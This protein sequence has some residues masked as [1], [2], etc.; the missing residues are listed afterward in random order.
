M[1]VTVNHRSM[2]WNAAALLG[3]LLLAAGCSKKDVTGA[4][5]PPPAVVEQEQGVRLFK[6]DHPDQFPLAVA[7]EYKA[8]ATLNVTGTVN[9]DIN[10]EVPVITLASG[11]VVDTYVQLGDT[12]KKG[13]LLMRVQSTDVSGAFDTY[14]KAV[15]DEH[16]A[17]KSLERAQLLY[18]HGA[19]AQSALQQ[20]QTTEQDAQA[21]VQAADEQL[22]VL[23][24]DKNH[25]GG[26]VN[27][28]APRS[29]VIVQ[30]NVTN[31]AATGV[32]L[33]GSPNAFT[34]ADLSSVWILCDVYE[35]DLPNV[36][37]GQTADI[38]INA[39]PEKV[40]TGRISN[41]S[42]VLDP[43]TRTAK[44]RI[45]VTNPGMLRVGMFVTATFHG[46]TQQMHAS[47]PASAV[48][49]LHDRDWIYIPANGGRFQ[50][51]AVV[52][53]E[54]L[55]GKMQ[56]ITSGIQPGQQVVTNALELQSTVEQ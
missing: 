16:L 7:Q 19:I 2:C 56:E 18:S 5:A 3:I 27:I 51:V 47:V 24:V 36:K 52:A 50:R 42:P 34:L 40:L 17:Q 38:H 14:M 20:A 1:N 35:N 30:Q 11:R 29:G 25:P 12:V 46:Q 15:N 54:M 45:D 21:D 55:P 6:P 37:L 53:G 28:Y 26:M 39:Y 23:G 43:N 48:L 44:V 31:A 9:P 41:I 10:R 33:A 13:Q 22:K 32:T 8:A 4:G 49:H